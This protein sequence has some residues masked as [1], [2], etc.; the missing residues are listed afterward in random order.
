[1]AD[2]N[3]DDKGKP[4]FRLMPPYAELEVVRVLTY[5]GNRYGD[6]NWKNCDDWGRY[7]DALGRHFNAYRRGE[8][9]DSDTGMHHLAHL[10]C[11]ALFQLEQDLAYYIENDIEEIHLSMD[12]SEL[13]KVMDGYAGITEIVRGDNGGDKTTAT[14]ASAD[15]DPEKVLLPK[16]RFCRACD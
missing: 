6:D 11:C 14:E 16:D 3:K 12:P 2:F 15:Y 10:I 1:M 5:G 7:I 13:R 4:R 8:M 9:N